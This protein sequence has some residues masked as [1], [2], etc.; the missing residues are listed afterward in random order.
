[1]KRTRRSDSDL[2]GTTHIPKRRKLHVAKKKHLKTLKSGLYP[3]FKG[4]TGHD[5]RAWAR[6]WLHV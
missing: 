3:I 6:E 2:E 4:S 1:M 5:R